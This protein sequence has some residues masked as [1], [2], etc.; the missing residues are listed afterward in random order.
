[1]QRFL[2]DEKMKL[3]QLL[4]FLCFC[5]AHF[6]AIAQTTFI[7]SENFAS[8]I[9]A[10]WEK[11]GISATSNNGKTCVSM[12]SNA[13]LITPMLNK[14]GSLTFSHR[15][16]GNG[17]TLIIEKSANNGV[18]EPV[19]TCSP[20]S[21]SGWGSSSF[22]VNETND[23]IKLRFVSSSATI[24]LTDIAVSALPNP[25]LSISADTLDLGIVF[26]GE[27]SS[28]ASLKVDARYLSSD[29]SVTVSGEGFEVSSDNQQFGTSAT[30]PK[31]ATFP[32]SIFVRYTS[33]SAA[34]GMV[35]GKVTF[36][37]EGAETVK[38][39]LLAQSSPTVPTILTSLQ[40][41]NFGYVLYGDTSLTKS[42]EV[43]A[44]YLSDASGIIKLTVPSGFL[45]STHENTGFTS[46]LSLP[47]VESVLP[48]TRIYIRFVPQGSQ[49]KKS[50]LGQITLKGGGATAF[51]NVSGIG[52]TSMEGISKQYFIS[53]SGND[54]SGDGSFSKPWYNLSK[55]VAVAQ[56]GDTIHVRGG[57]Y[58]YDQ[59]IRLTTSGAAG[60]RICIFAWKKDDGSFE[61]PVFDFSKQTYGA[62]NRAILITGNY[63]YLFGIHITKAGDNGI[64]L[65]GN[66]C[67]L[68]RCVFSY[69][70]DSGVQLGFGHT[71]SDTH[72][73]IS[74]NNGSYCA[75]NVVVDCDSYQ[76]YDPDNYG[77]DADGFACKMHNGRGNWFLRCRAWNNSDDAWD[78]YE[79]D[80]PV[81]IIECWGWH[82][83]DAGQHPVSGGSF[84]GNGNGMKLGGNGTGGSSE[85]KH[86]AWNSIAFNCNK[87]NSVKGFDQNS[88][89]GGV[90]LVN[91]LAFNNG[92]DFMFEDSPSSATNDFYNNVC[93]S[94]RIEINSTGALMENNAAI[95]NPSKG[96]L[97]PVKVS[98][99]AA[100]FND[101]S[102][103]AAK[104]PR[105]DDGALPTGFA[106]LLR[107]SKLVDM[108]KSDL[109]CPMPV[110]LDQP[111][112]GSAMNLAQA[113]KGKAR[114]LGPYESDFTS[115]VIPNQVSG[116]FFYVTSNKTG[117]LEIH[118]QLADN[119]MASELTITSASG[120]LVIAEKIFNT[121]KSKESFRIFDQ[122]RTGTY[123]IRLK[124]NSSILTRKVTIR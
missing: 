36:S 20:S 114:D 86:E 45:V 33:P 93:L 74:K 83:G 60:K 58:S 16:S 101:L 121:I 27:S 85:G 107:S 76:N 92:Y 109:T 38:T 29:L 118:Y 35:S 21:S 104:M 4:I 31:S 11:S 119:A 105:F 91:C 22:S 90:K 43:L 117:Y 2:F 42:I 57:K 102:E 72:P 66:Y 5:L 59:T 80:F 68:E 52:I 48:G 17:K 25:E 73:G 113:V 116:N 1:L 10:N 103:D 75:Y 9:P 18:W 8:G 54:F 67:I 96:W 53:P 123:L 98:F 26:T 24:Y 14:P 64:K 32:A 62:N 106:R 87:T 49:H 100:D 7:I 23:N 56:A 81:Y 94:N 47:F 79:T 50:F 71:F 88:H 34:M 77:S 30:L 55:A 82:S 41:L 40:S 15:A 61:K 13:Y 70:G 115:S 28:A 95:R 37:T 84:Q 46:E 39:I 44:K 89:K 112:V 65:E 120:Q 69:N 110:F 122:L 12:G 3:K 63:W 99:S 19:G 78:L 111:L 108:G 6:Y 97:N 124:S 51:L